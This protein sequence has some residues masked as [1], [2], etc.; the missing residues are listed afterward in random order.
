VEGLAP[1]HQVKRGDGGGGN[2]DGNLVRENH[3]RGIH[4]DGYSIAAR[5]RTGI[6]R[7]REARLLDRLEEKR[8]T[9]NETG[10]PGR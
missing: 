1:A 2:G 4:P 3:A 5:D 7:D 8:R 9:E 6:P 10:P